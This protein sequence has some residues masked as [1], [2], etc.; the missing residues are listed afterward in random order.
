MS[1]ETDNEGL[2]VDIAKLLE[3]AVEQ[4]NQQQPWHFRLQHDVRH[5]Q[6]FFAF[7]PTA[8]HNESGQLVPINSWLDEQITIR[9]TTAQIDAISNTFAESLTSKTGYHFSCCR[10]FFFSG[11]VSLKTVHLEAV[12][13]TA[14]LFLE[15]L[16]IAHPEVDGGS[17]RLMCE[18]MD[19]R[20]CFIVVKPAEHRIPRTAPQ[21]GVCAA[22]GYDPY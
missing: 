17:Y 6:S 11:A 21:S 22:D 15:D 18:P 12:D 13:Q 7:V 4:V 14:R 3:E 19:K 16:I 20:F 5:D 9:P 10:D 8:T 1:F 2:P